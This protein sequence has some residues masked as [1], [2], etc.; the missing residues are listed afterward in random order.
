VTVERAS[1]R[2]RDARLKALAE[3]YLAALNRGDADA[4]LALFHVDATVEDP[5]GGTRLRGL[6]EIEPF[7]RRA[8]A[9][10]LRVELEAPI[11]G[12]HGDCAAYAMRVVLADMT[13][14]VIGVLAFD[15]EDLITEM[16]AYHGPSDVT[17]HGGD[18]P[19]PPKI[20][21]CC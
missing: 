4:V 17:A 8:M 7:Y 16:R 2:P 9:R 1:D 11:R 19:I 12:S 18:E 10:D 3:R 6:T 20:A 14:R 21:T 5:V 15:A 13:L